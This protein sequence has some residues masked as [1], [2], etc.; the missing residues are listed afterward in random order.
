MPRTPIIAGN[1]KMNTLR[2][3]RDRARDGIRERVDGIARR[4]EDRLPAFRLPPRRRS[5]ALAGSTIAV[6][7]QNVVL[8]GEGRLHGRSEHDAGRRGRDARHHRPQRAPPVL[9][10]D[11][12]DGEPA[13]AVARSPTASSPIM[14]VGETLEQ[15][16][17]GEDRRRARHARRAAASTASSVGATFIIAYEPVWAIGTG[18]AADGRHGAAG[19]RP[20]PRAPCAMSPAPS[21]TTCASSTAARSRRRTSPSTWRQ[22]DVDGGLVGGASLKAESFT[23]MLA[24]RRCRRDA[25]DAS[26][27]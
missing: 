19:D 8:G 3:R 13:R 4:R 22:P 18:L 21:P 6:G 26:P 7:A 10:R 24:Q 2:R 25:P 5:A 1:W 27:R 23:A 14:C 11:R 12:R 16:E 17:A 15:R 20:H 9:R